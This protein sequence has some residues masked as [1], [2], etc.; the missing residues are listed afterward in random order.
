MLLTQNIFSE[1]NLRLKRFQ[2]FTVSFEN[3]QAFY[4]PVVCADNYKLH[5]TIYM[6]TY[7]VFQFLFYER[8]CFP[9]LRTVPFLCASSIFS[10]F[11]F[12]LIITCD[13]YFQSHSPV[14]LVKIAYAS[15]ANVLGFISLAYISLLSSVYPNVISANFLIYICKC[16]IFKVIDMPFCFAF[17]SKQIF[18]HCL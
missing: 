7:Q 9:L 5:S 2:I 14:L 3:V 18:L 8:F 15:Q 16:S 12:N 4:Q 17:C 11:F 10:G 6:C 1:I 13:L